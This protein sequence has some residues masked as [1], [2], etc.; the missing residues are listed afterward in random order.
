MS[1]I[2]P[3]IITIGYRLLGYFSLGEISS[4]FAYYQELSLHIFSQ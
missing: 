2:P 1:F 4:L 3:F